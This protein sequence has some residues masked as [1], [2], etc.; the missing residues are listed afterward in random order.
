MKRFFKLFFL[1][2][3]LSCVSLWISGYGYIFY[4]LRAT[5]LRFEKTA[6]IDDAK[7]FYNDTVF[8]SE[9]RSNGKNQNLTI[10]TN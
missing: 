9:N 4:G 7:F 2:V 5:Y 6:Q 3:F 1:F 10:V 8:A